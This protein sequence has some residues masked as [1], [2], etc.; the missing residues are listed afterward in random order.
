MYRVPASAPFALFLA[1]L[2]RHPR[3]AAIKRFGY[4]FTLAAN[5]LKYLSLS[6]RWNVF[7]FCPPI[8]NLLT[9]QAEL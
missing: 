4:R 9:Y 8:N 6:G 2:L 1:R 5:P 7:E 3:V